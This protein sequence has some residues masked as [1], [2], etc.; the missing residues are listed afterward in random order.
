MCCPPL[1]PL[2][3]YKIFGDFCSCSLYLT[4]KFS[5][6]YQNYWHWGGMSLLCLSRKG[7]TSSTWSSLATSHLLKI[8][9]FSYYEQE[10]DTGFMFFL[11]LGII[12]H[13]LLP[14]STIEDNLAKILWGVFVLGLGWYKFFVECNF[15]FLSLHTSNLFFDRKT[16]WSVP[17]ARGVLL[18]NPRPRISCPVGSSPRAKIVRFITMRIV[19]D[20]YPHLSFLWGPKIG[21]TCASGAHL[22]DVRLR[23]ISCAHLKPPTIYK[24]LLDLLHLSALPITKL[25]CCILYQN[26]MASSTCLCAVLFQSYQV[27]SGCLFALF[28]SK[29]SA[30]FSASTTDITRISCCSLLRVLKRS[31]L[32]IINSTSEWCGCEEMCCDLLGHAMI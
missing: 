14:T 31:I 26:N 3:N 7:L 27:N 5:A 22:K 15:D 32:G 21:S 10:R 8:L 1:D 17:C 12:L 9:R 2:R 11:L 24:S 23:P 30:G 29:T 25:T 20:S 28:S 19:L 18:Q 6:L 13:N 16:I 4:P